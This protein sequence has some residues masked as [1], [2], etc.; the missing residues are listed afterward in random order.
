VGWVQGR[1]Q[2]GPLTVL[3][4]TL[5]LL[6]LLDTATGLGVT[7]W[8]VG[9]LVAVV[10]WLLVARGMHREGLPTLGP[11]N[12]VTLLRAVLAAGLTAL[13][14]ESWTGSVPRSLVVLLASL[15]LA[16]DLVDGWLARR[17]GKVTG[18]GAAFDMETDAWV[19]LVLSAYVVP[20]VGAWVLLIGLARYLLLLAGLARPW[21]TLPPP[22]RPWAKVV[23]A[24]QDVVLVVVAA[25]VLPRLAAQAVTLLA[26]ALLAESF[27]H[28]VLALR[29][30]RH[31]RVARPSWLPPVMDAVALVV[32]Y[33]ALA[34][35]HSTD[36]LTAAV[37]L[38]IPL[39]LL[40]FLALALVLPS[41]WGRVV[42]VVSGVLLAAAVVVSVL[43][44]GF[45]EGLDRPFNPISDP[46]YLG[47][48]FDLL[49]A[50]MG[51][52]GAIVASAGILGALGL[53]TAL[54]VWSVLRTRRTVRAAPQA[55]TA[56]IL[57]LTVVWA[58]A[59]AGGAQVGGV[60]V[61]GAPAASLV[62]G[63]VDQ[64]RAELADRAA[65]ERALSHDRF[66]RT[67]GRDLL[68]RLRGKDVLVVFVESYGRVAVED[69]WFSPLVDRT[70]TGATGRLA[71]LGF[72]ARS[73]WL[74]SPT[75]GGFSWHA[76]STF[77]SGLWIDSEQRYDQVLASN[78]FNLSWAF[79]K[80]GWRTVA[81]VPSNTG[82][83]PEGQRFY[84]YQRMY[85]DYD[86]GYAGPRLGYARI[87]DQ[88]T[89]G[90]FIDRELTPQHRPVM[91]E[92]DLDTSHMP[93]IPLPR[94]V[95]WNTLGDGLVYSG[96]H[97]PDFSP[98]STFADS[99]AQQGHYARSIRY[100]LRS[101]VGFVRHAHDKNLVMVV[102]GDHQPHSGV[103]GTDASHDVPIS[104]V[105]HDP[106]VLRQIS[107]WG[108]TPGL[109]P[110]PDLP[111]VPMNDFRDR[112][113]TAFGSRPTH[114][115]G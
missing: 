49:E 104:L 55:W 112:F 83:W 1:V 54:C 87:P 98:L 75:F 31:E 106:A 91:A 64:V 22:S 80:A 10:T 29:H 39:E 44:L 27:L 12:R 30:R 90:A 11:A 35:P 19:I 66:A 28:Q 61:A 102:L 85:G 36:Q 65:F 107:G 53:G 103:S 74:E 37:L 41:T 8:A 99:H 25:D 115:E 7:A 46:G 18:L 15:T 82:P 40:V 100:S 110:D 63:Q 6:A 4:A 114:P 47:G 73:G 79:R 16:L 58:V 43:D 81:D 97:D 69:S 105:A 59:G 70:L 71:R 17:Q 5:L 2:V 26:L 101:L 67:P 56:V 34:L 94:L 60:S 109:H 77:Q 21:L 38:A 32:I 78:R 48:G 93:W 92:I 62:S 42:A 68:T 52:A 23:A 72:H 88:W 95:P 84:R 57:G 113:L 14:V 51:L 108:W 9:G 50:S 20:L 89:L 96:M 86:V 33:L 24:V 13:V 45:E 76:H 3:P 111:T